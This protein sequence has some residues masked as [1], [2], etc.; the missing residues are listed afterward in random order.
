M[1]SEMDSWMLS[2]VAAA[3]E[4]CNAGF[5]T[6]DFPKATTACYN[7]WLYDLC[8]NYLE[9]LKPLAAKG[10]PE[11]VAVAKSTLYIVLDAGLRL[12]SPFMPFITEELFQRLPR[13]SCWE[14]PSICVTSYPESRDFPWRDLTREAEF[15]FVQKIIHAIRS[16]KSNYNMP[17]KANT[18]G[19]H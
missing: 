7:L 5:E 9:Y 8:D 10:T 13:K 2:R 4:S 12:L 19:T 14:P 15:E 11:E 6:Y 16:A 17:T 3:V 1:R 18:E